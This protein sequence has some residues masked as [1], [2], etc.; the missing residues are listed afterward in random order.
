MTPNWPLVLRQIIAATDCE[1]HDIAK[2]CGVCKSAVEQ[3]LA[4]VKS[5]NFPNGWALLNAYVEKVG[6]RIPQA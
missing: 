4:G 1:V 3:W 5:P 6:R 2:H